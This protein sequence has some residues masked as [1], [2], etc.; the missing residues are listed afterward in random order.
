MAP[1]YN[2]LESL[3]GEFFKTPEGLHQ[4][5]EDDYSLVERIA[6]EN[7]LPLLTYG[8]DGVLVHMSIIEEIKARFKHGDLTKVAPNEAAPNSRYL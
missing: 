4:F 7:H 2:K 1:E 3:Y 6:E 8:K 5:N